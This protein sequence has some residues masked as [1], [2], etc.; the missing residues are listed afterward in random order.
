LLESAGFCVVEA[1]DVTPAYRFTQEQ[2]L[3]EW[4]RRSD[5]LRA[6][7][8]AELFDERQEER[9]ATRRAIDAGLLRRSFLLAVR[10]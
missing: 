3:V 2:W 4:D 8:G 6:L 5:D 1:V 7:L 9:R 10:R